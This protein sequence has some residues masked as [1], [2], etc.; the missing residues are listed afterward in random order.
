M[1]CLDVL[2]SVLDRCGLP[3][4]RS[5]L[6]LGIV[7]VISYFLYSDPSLSMIEFLLI[8]ASIGAKS[9][10]LYSLTKLNYKIIAIQRMR[11]GPILTI[12]RTT[13]CIH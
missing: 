4:S 12:P 10:T 8:A 5:Y 3:D 7:D 11:R 9:R 1:P 2:D 6:S 13:G